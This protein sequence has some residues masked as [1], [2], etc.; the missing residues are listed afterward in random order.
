[1]IDAP[2]QL[3]VSRTPATQPAPNPNTSL[4]HSQDTALLPADHG[5]SWGN[6][7]SSDMLFWSSSEMVFWSSKNMMILWFIAS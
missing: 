1:M 5:L 2:F 3:G 7:A 6:A 4:Q